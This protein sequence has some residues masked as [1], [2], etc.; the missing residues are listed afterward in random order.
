MDPLLI[1]VQ[2][3]ARMLAVGRTSIYELINSG[4]LETKKLGR[5]RLVT[6]DSIRRV[7]GKQS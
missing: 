3:A 2:E 5:R 7:A 1:S 6:I 4:E